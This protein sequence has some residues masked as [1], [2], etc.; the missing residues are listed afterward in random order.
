MHHQHSPFLGHINGFLRIF[1]NRYIFFVVILDVIQRHPFH[2]LHHQNTKGLLLL[3]GSNSK[4]SYSFTNVLL[5]IQC[6]VTFS[7]VINLLT[8]PAVD[9][10]HFDRTKIHPGNWT[11]PIFQILFNSWIECIIWYCYR[12][13]LQNKLWLHTTQGSCFM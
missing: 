5:N 12:I 10:H 9:R 6:V 4:W 11:L 8:R 13:F 1:H 3:Y 2:F 7:I